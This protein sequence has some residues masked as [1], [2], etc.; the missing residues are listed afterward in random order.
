[1]TVDQILECLERKRIRAT[2]GAVGAVIGRPARSVGAALGSRTQRA[3]WVVRARDGEPTGYDPHRKHPDLY[4]TRHIIKTG[5]ELRHRCAESHRCR[6][7]KYVLPRLVIHADWSTSPGKRWCAIAGLESDGRYRVDAPEPVGDLRTYFTRLLRRAGPD[8]VVLSGFDFPIGLPK[9]YADKA[10]LI[11]FRTALSR[12]GR[13]RWID[14]YRP[15]AAP[16]EISVTRPFYPTSPRRGT[17]PQHLVERLGMRHV[18]E[19]YRRC[20]VHPHRTRAAPL[21]W[22]VGGKQVGKA[23]ITGWRNLLAPALL[24]KKKGVPVSIWP[25]DGC[26]AELLARPGLVVAETYPAE[27]YRHLDLAI[28]RSKRSKR[29]QSDRAEDAGPMNDWVRTN[30]V[31]LTDRL[32]AEIADGFGDDTDGEDRFD[33]VVGLFGMLDVVLGN[34]ASGEPDDATT[35]IEGW[36]LGQPIAPSTGS[37]RMEI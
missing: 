15:A 13:G 24:A 5:D 31:R 33:A 7:E 26:L 11:S 10:R 12:F 29:R 34:S 22:L 30:R 8:A 28:R 3:S 23:A 6:Q 35:R 2:Y 16:S 4:R 20:E 19:L 32:H 1:M 18:D 37:V 17:S 21:F 9:S 25:F 27:S 14:F 36:I